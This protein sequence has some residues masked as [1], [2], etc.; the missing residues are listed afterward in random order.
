M[1]CGPGVY[2]VG[3]GSEL[4][5]FDHDE[6]KQQPRHGAT[7]RHG[8]PAWPSPLSS[9]WSPPW[10]P[11]RTKRKRKPVITGNANRTEHA[12]RLRR[13]VEAEGCGCYAARRFHKRLSH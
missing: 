2:R 12:A 6:P 7:E 9:S 5:Q 13:F 10:P 11:K 3:G 4:E 1:F 8:P